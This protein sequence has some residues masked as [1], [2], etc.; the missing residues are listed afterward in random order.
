M[1]LLAEAQP[2]DLVPHAISYNAAI[3]DCELGLQPHTAMVAII[4]LAAMQPHDMVTD[5]TMHSATIGTCEQKG[6]AALHS[7]DF[8]GRCA[9]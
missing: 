7:H 2:R 3:S 5:A 1:T 6:A 9:T 4:L 8:V